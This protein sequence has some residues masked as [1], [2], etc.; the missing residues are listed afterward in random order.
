M[1]DPVGYRVSEPEPSAAPRSDSFLSRL[2]NL[3]TSPGKAMEGVKAKPRWLQ[4]G[5]VIMVVMGL[6]TAATTHIASPEQMELMKDTRLGQMIPPEQ[7]QEQY[8]QALN[9]TMGKRII[10]GIGAAAGTWILA[11]FVPGLVWLLFS[12]LA[13][14]QATFGQVMGVVFWADLIPLGLGPLVRWP[15]VLAQQSVIGVATG[16]AVFA[17]GD[18]SSLAYRLL[19]F[20]DVFAIWGLV[21]M[22]IGFQKVNGFPRG[23]A[24]TV[25]VVPWLLISLVQFGLMS[26]FM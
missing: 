23:K 16:P 12:K 20:L 22:V 4:A 26:A 1:Q 14:G 8:D 21:V 25:A 17:A 3:I 7:Y 19:M 10:S 9:P 11:L 2:G 15:L 13:G 6:F 18:P 24:V 5:L